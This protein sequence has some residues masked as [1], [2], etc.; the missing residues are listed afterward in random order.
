MKGKMELTISV[1]RGRARRAARFIPLLGVLALGGCGLDEWARNGGKV[2]PNYTAPLA[3]VASEWIDYKDPRVKSTD[4]DLS[5]WWGIF[6]DPVLDEL[7]DEASK[8]NLTLRVAGSRI[9]EARARRGIAIGNLFPQNQEAVGSLT[10]NKASREAAFSTND[11]WFTNAEAGFNLS[12]EMDFWGRFRRG[13]EASD[14][15]LD[16]S[17]ENYDDVLVILLSDVA[18]NYVQWR[19]FQERLSYARQNLEIQGKSYQ[20]TKD[21]FEAGATTERDVQQ[22]RQ[23]LEE[24]RAL[25]PQLEAGLRQTGNAMCVLLGI[26]TRDL[27]ERLKEGKIPVAGREVAIGIPADLLRRRPDVRRAER[28]AAAQSA[29]IGIAKADLYPRFSLIGGLGL[30][31]EHFNDL[32]KT[33]GSLTGTIGPAF[34]WDILNYG[35]IENSVRVQE[36]RFQGF[37]N[38]YQDAVLR[39]GR[40]TEDSLIGFM[41]AQER[42]A[43]L[44]QSVIAAQRTVEISL[45]QY[46]E[47]VI[48][49]TPV[50]LF[51]RTL[52]D[53]Q[54]QLAVARGEIALNLVGLYRSLGGGWEMRP[55]GDGEGNATTRP[56]PQQVSQP[57]PQ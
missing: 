32:F 39:A 46:K 20:L 10:H 49:F 41:K 4:E 51:Q 35:R 9:A 45:D 5:Q 33:P 17:I 31:S 52:T 23:V 8:Q 12:W 57:A 55:S 27:T 2:G 29:R 1:V 34:Q 28:E 15:D 18:T 42:A 48:D 16:A 30:Q 24:T 13:I 11:Q 36:A 43:S 6:K 56:A 26:P 53:Q 40:D 37:F 54:D 22:A 38:A 3:P 21:K 19:L 44:E 7:I 50:F 14:A 25:V 47:G